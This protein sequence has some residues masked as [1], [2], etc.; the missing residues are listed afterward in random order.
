MTGLAARFEPYQ[1]VAASG[2][3]AGSQKAGKRA[4]FGYEIRMGATCEFSVL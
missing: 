3:L 2:P 1:I 4:S